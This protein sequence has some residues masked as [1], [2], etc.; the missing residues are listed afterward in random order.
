[1][2]QERDIYSMSDYRAEREYWIRTHPAM[3]EALIELWKAE[4]VVWNVQEALGNVWAE[5]RQ[6]PMGI[7]WKGTPEEEE[8]QK[9]IDARRS[10]FAAKVA[11][12][13]IPVPPAPKENT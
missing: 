7:I 11:A 12:Y 13:N 9:R 3:K 10:E 4:R 2:R 1:M 6:N 5:S 8:Q